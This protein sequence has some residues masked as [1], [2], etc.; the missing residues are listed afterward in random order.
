MKVFFDNRDIKDIMRLR[1]CKAY[2]HGR[3]I[4]EYLDSS[5]MSCKEKIFI[6]DKILEYLKNKSEKEKSEK[7]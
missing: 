1:K 2:I 7:R 5:H 4:R 3:L 6:C